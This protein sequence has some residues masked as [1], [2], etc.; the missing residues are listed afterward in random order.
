MSTSTFNNYKIRDASVRIDINYE[1][2]MGIY[3]DTFWSEISNGTY[4]STTFDFLENL[5]NSG[6]EYFIDIGAATGCMSLY[7]ASTGLK[8]ISVE[9]QEMVYAALTRNLELNPSLSSQI[10]LVYALVSKSQDRISISESFTPGAAGPIASGKLTSNSI[11]IK[12]LLESCD[13]QSKTA[14]KIDI[15]GAE[16]PLLTDKTTIDLLSHWKPLIYIALHPGFKRP[17][18]SNA[19]YL[20]RFLWRIQASR[21]IID[22][23][24]AVSSK[25]E[26]YI[27]SNKKKVNLLE[28]LFALKRDEKDYLLVF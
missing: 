13:V 26:I 3:G 22:F 9:P 23:F 27:A 10:S 16:F 5:Y 21:D 18:K 2:S 7:A 25:A 17:L 20:S 15:E 24:S 8:V 11:T 12:Q 1:S 6:Y 4:E 28:L 14:I 19:S